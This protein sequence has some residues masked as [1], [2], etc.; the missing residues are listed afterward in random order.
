MLGGE[1]KMIANAIRLTISVGQIL[2][3]SLFGYLIYLTFKYKSAFAW[4]A[5]SKTEKKRAIVI[6]LTFVC[7]ILVTITLAAYNT[8]LWS[9]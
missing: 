3:M 9:R 7:S 8:G 2:L 5:A 1:T 4:V 6:F